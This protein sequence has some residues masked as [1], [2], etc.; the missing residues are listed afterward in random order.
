MSHKKKKF[1]VH[2]PPDR[3][4]R[5]PMPTVPRDL[6]PPYVPR[7]NRHYGNLGRSGTQFLLLALL[8]VVLGAVLMAS[9]EAPWQTCLPLVVI[10]VIVSLLFY[11]FRKKR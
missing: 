4:H 5:D 10:V 9:K 8:A 2:G 11:L 1:K 7:Y 6:V 3:R